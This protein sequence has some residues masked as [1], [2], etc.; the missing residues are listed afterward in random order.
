MELVERKKLTSAKREARNAYLFLSP[1]ILLF[2]IFII[3]P[4]T[5][6]ILLSFTVFDSVN[7]PK[8]NFLL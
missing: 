8:L 7:F 1:Y 4:I 5:I 2:I 6:A 3:I